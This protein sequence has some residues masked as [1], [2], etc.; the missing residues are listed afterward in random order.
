MV[1]LD[2]LSKLEVSCFC[3]FAATQ[4]IKFRTIDL[5]EQ[6][7]LFDDDAASIPQIG[8]SSMSNTIELCK[9][10]DLCSLATFAC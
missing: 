8:S 9:R 2:G 1:L 3:L 5:L 7:T 6:V 4:A 10:P